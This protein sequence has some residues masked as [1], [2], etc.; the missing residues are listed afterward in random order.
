MNA[1]RSDDPGATLSFDLSRPGRVGCTLP[2]LDVP[3]APL[4]ADLLRDDVA[5]PELSQLDVVRYFTRLS[6]RN[7]SIDTGCYPLGS[8]SMK[9]NPKV[10]EDVAR[11]PGLAQ[12]HPMQPKSTTQGALKLLFELQRALAEITGMDDVSLAPAAGAHGELAGI[13]IARAYLHSNGG[14]ARRRV[15]VADSAHGTNPATA[16]MAGFEVVSVPTD[17]H[18]NMALDKLQRALDANGDGVAALMLTL[19]STL[20]LFEP[21]IVRIAEL[22]HGH[23]A[24]LYGDG[25]NMNAML[26]RV[27]PGDLGF[28]VF[29]LNLHKTFSTPHGGGGPGAGPIA[30]K[31]HLVPF[32]PTPH[33]RQNEGNGGYVLAA[34]ERSIG[35]LGLFAGNFGVLVRAYAYI[36]SL[37]ADGLRSISE[38]AVLNANYVQAR[39]RD[40]YRLPYDRRCMHETVFSGSRQKAKGVRTLDIAKR[41]IDYGFHPP[42]IYFPL[43]VD[44]ALMIEPTES[45]TKETLDAFC[46]ALLAIAREAEDSPDLVREAPHDAPLG[47]LDEATAARKPVLRWRRRR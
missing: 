6:Q 21:H 43:I 11:L 30:V 24:L 18:G 46:D 31:S 13:L 16:A 34:P 14:G 40:A 5:L 28:D 27:K 39:L 20:G 2:P 8:C 1:P 9:Y 19:P 41:L 25:A 29:H 37:G 44:E 36:R 12:V 35:R 15:L 33:L 17:A 4:P 3:E 38:A 47:R 45:E 10:N 26:G 32:L 23:G 7:Y 42:T 22:V